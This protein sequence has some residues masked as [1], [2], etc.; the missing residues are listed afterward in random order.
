VLSFL[1]SLGA[2]KS[3]PARPD[4]EGTAATTRNVL[5]DWVEDR[6]LDRPPTAKRLK[7][8]G[9]VDMKIEFSSYACVSTSTPLEV[10]AIRGMQLGDFIAQHVLGGYALEA[11]PDSSGQA[12]RQ[13]QGDLWHSLFV[14]WCQ[15]AIQNLA[16]VLALCLDG[17]GHG[18]MHVLVKDKHRGCSGRWDMVAVWAAYLL[19]MF[20][21]KF[22]ST[23]S[24]CNCAACD[25]LLVHTTQYGV[26]DM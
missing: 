16:G 23:H 19:K 3:A 1:A 15:E 7:R 8:A 24:H 5:V 20:P 9:V 4:A 12:I 17:Y 25:V 14:F 18:K 10:R 11:D 6:V 2:E 21:P 26:V 13:H 22:V